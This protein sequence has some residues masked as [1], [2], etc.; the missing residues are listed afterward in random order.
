MQSSN[1]Y[2]GLTRVPTRLLVVGGIHLAVVWALINGLHIRTGA[3]DGPGDITT[4]FLEQERPAPETIIPPAVPRTT[5]KLTE[6]PL[7]PDVPNIINTDSDTAITP[8]PPPEFHDPGPPAIAE[9]QTLVTGAA[10]DPRHP[11]TQPDYPMSSRRLD[12]QGK[13][14]LSVLVGPD[15]HV[16]EVKVTQSSGSPR[17]DQAAVNEARAHW[18]LRPATRNGVPF[19]QWLTLGVVFRLEN[20]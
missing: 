13:V 20:R 6:Q 19:E 15:G 3:A 5:I 10:V 11:L 7:L 16:L 4:Q 17:L 1:S 2:V 12:E 18:R 9:P 14:A 8:A